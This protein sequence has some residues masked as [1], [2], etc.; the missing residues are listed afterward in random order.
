MENTFTYTTKGKIVSSVEKVLLHKEPK[1]EERFSYMMKNERLNFQIA[2][3]SDSPARRNNRLT[4][5]GTL[6]P[7]VSFRS[8]ENVPVTY[9]APE[10]DDYYVGKEP[11]V[12]P[13][14]LKPF[15]AMGLVL[16]C[17]QWKSIWVSIENKAD[18]PVG[19]HTLTFE[20]HYES[21]EKALALSY[22]VEVLDAVAEGNGL[23][24][25]N[26]VHY[27]CICAW[28][29][30]KP[31]TDKFYDV[32]KKYLQVYVDCGYNMLLTPLFT[33]PLDTAV[34]GERPTV[35]LVDV[36]VID[37]KYYFE[38]SKLRKFVSFAQENG[39][40]YFEFSHLFTQWGGKFCPKIV[41]KKRGRLQKI[42][43]W[44]V[45]ANSTSYQEFLAAFL[46]LLYREIVG[47]GLQDVSY[48]HLTD[49]PNAQSVEMYANCCALIKKYMPAIPTIDALS[50]PIYCERNI[51]DIPVP[52]TT[53]YADF[54]RFPLKEKFVYYCCFPNNEY[55][56]NRFINMPG[57]RTRILGMQLYQTG[58]NGFLHWGFNF[59]NSL[60]AIERINPYAETN[61]CGFYPGGD[62]FIVYPGDHQ[63]YYSIRSE[64]MKEAVQ[65]YN[66]LKTLAS[67][68]G[69]EFVMNILAKAGINGYNE[70]PRQTKSFLKL[71]KEIYQQIKNVFNNGPKA[72]KA[73]RQKR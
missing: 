1:T 71:R 50:N 52:I 72:F 54:T 67:L 24:L 21:G 7:Y 28:H 2:L 59:Y 14:L 43:G 6:A 15:G 57:V 22:T 4:V 25:T 39:I 64:L 46:P 19:K 9:T 55:Y 53:H 69:K 13:D 56:S 30:V 45:A 27:D 3:F 8:V 16:P 58:V 12:Y 49:E 47:L 68:Q 62:G 51:V 36:D 70:Y 35:Q 42:F 32:L 20:L 44:H 29:K 61:A 23:K 38:F 18:L 37:G 17:R 73:R 41:A 40:K 10:A 33:P 11:G 65:D 63:I 5:S 60:L 31:F 48:M 34:G 26:W 66:A